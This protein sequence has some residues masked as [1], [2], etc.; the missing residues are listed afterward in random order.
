MPT[1]ARR[2]PHRM[3]DPQH[4]VDQLR[5]AAAAAARAGYCVSPVK[6]GLKAP[7]I[8]NWEQEA[9]RDPATITDWWTSVPRNIGIAT[10]RSGLLV[11]YLDHGH[12]QPAPPPFTDARDGLDVLTQLA[13]AAYVTA[14]TDTFTVLT[15]TGGRHLYFRAPTG[16]EL[17]NTQGKLGWRI[18]T[19]AHGG[20]VVAAGSIRPEGR[21]RIVRPGPVRELPGWLLHRL[22]PPPPGQV[23]WRRRP[24]LLPHSRAAAYVRGAVEREAAQVA[25]A[26]PGTSHATLLAAAR[27]L[28]QLVGGG[29]LTRRIRDRAAVTGL[30]RPPGTDVAR[31]ILV[32]GVV[33]KLPMGTYARC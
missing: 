30:R 2:H 19:R 10:G 18:D 4:L 22:T 27:K 8:E 21:Y 13:A 6:P 32:L 12:G 9:T 20:F 23:L 16:T 17:R 26:A 15:P 29:V 28:G 1:R 14:P 11:V 24:L 31:V 5:R 33:R 3:R 7:A 25:A